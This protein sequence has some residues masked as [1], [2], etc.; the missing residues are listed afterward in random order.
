MLR[1][2]SVEICAGAGGQA[3]GL[4][5]AGFA[6]RVLIEIDPAACE[7]LRLNNEHHSLG[8]G[9]IVEGCVKHFAEYDAR[10]F[11]G[12]DLVAGGVPCPPFSKAGKQLGKDDERDLFPT[13]LKIVSTIQPKAVMIENVAGLLDPKFKPYREELDLS[14]SRMGYKTFWK[15]HHASDYGVP[16]LRPR[17]L[18]VALRD[19]YAGHFRWPS[20]TITPPTVGEALFDLMAEN[21]WEGAEAWKQSANTIAPTLVGGSHKHGG[22]DLGPTRAKKA[23]QVLGVNGHSIA[24]NGPEKEFIGYVGRDGKIRAGFENMPR[25]NVRMAARIQGF[26][27]W[28]QFSGKKTAAYRQVGNAFPPPVAEATGRQIRKA[29]EAVDLL[30][31]QQLT[32]QLEANDTQSLRIA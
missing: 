12:V 24:D 29:L 15:L 31:K 8:W 1:Y 10:N 9:K 32:L 4:H 11:S 16:Q 26:P 7:T 22:P 28:W 21:G 2:T 17:V 14:L 23:W 25:L 20:E 19:E 13:A 6:H 27:D 30:K 3:L 18:L 5:N